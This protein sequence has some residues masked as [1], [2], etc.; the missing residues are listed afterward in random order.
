MELVK[1]SITSSWPGVI[2][3]DRR[4]VLRGH[5]ISC[6]VGIDVQFR[7]FDKKKKN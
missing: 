7:S 3:Q 4:A 2:W 6:S 1:N 5:S